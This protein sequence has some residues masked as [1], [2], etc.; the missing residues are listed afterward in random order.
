MS[1]IAKLKRI[2]K[3]IVHEDGT[4]DSFDK[5][6]I[7]LMSGIF[8]TRYPLIISENTN[9]LD[10]I[11][12][13]TIDS[14]LTMNV[15]TVVKL[16]EKHDMGYEFVSNCERYLKESVLAFDSL[17]FESSKVVLLDELDDDGYPMI[18]ICRENKELGGNLL[19]NEITSVYDKEKLENLISR[20]FSLN[21][22]FY[23]NKKTEQYMKSIGFQF[24]Q[25]LTYALSTNYNSRSFCKSQVERELFEN[26][27]ID[28]A[29]NYLDAQGFVDYEEVV[30][31]L[32]EYEECQEWDE[33]GNMVTGTSID[34]M[35]DWIKHRSY[36][37]L[38]MEERG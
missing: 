11:E 27:F 15:S 28:L 26:Q 18:A 22:M 21:K 23:K 12:G 25:G 33:N 5:Q 8:D 32:D 19:V 17:Q 3:N 20:T 37:N 2:N 10:Y 31:M 6:L 30:E 34:E 29:T 1:N 24:P 35:S 7:Q 4:I 14:P 36:N 9:S 38:E 16:R 13:F